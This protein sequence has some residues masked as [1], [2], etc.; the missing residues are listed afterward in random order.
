MEVQFIALQ[1][2]VTQRLCNT[3]KRKMVTLANVMVEIMN[4]SIDQIREDN[5][6]SRLR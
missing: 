4:R 3:I 5:T 1:N 2:T 6:R